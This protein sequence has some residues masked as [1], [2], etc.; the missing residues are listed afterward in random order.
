MGN[1]DEN[2]QIIN[3]PIIVIARI[4]RMVV[5]STAEADVAL[6]Y[7]AAKKKFTTTSHIRRSRTQATTYARTISVQMDLVRDINCI[8]NE[9]MVIF[10]NQDC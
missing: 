2:S 6:L 3:G 7:H 10:S 1:K 8:N 5:A 4:L 9:F